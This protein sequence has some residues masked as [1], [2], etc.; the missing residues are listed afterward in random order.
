MVLL[1]CGGQEKECKVY[2]PSR[3]NL[4]AKDASN[5][6]VDGSGEELCG[7]AP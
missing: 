7:D 5:I 1:N 2:Q 6:V 4:R 3:S